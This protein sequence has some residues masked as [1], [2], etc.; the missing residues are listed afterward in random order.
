MPILIFWPFLKLSAKLIRGDIIIINK[1]IIRSSIYIN[2]YIL[3]VKNN[4]KL[5]VIYQIIKIFAC[6][7]AVQGYSME[8]CMLY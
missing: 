4:S 7:F 6:S 8:R 1:H 2:N 3:I 5:L